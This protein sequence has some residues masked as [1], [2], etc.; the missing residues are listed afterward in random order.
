MTDVVQRQAVRSPGRMRT[1]LYP[2]EN[3]QG[4]AAWQA[5]SAGPGKPS[6]FPGGRVLRPRAWNP[7]TYHTEW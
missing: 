4:Y 1:A 7:T 2:S 5:Y 6:P 3:A